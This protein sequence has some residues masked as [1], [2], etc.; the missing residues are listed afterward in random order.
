MISEAVMS[1]ALEWQQSDP[2]GCLG[3]Q[4]DHGEVHDNIKLVGERIRCSTRP[5]VVIRIKGRAIF[6]HTF[7]KRTGGIKAS[8][9]SQSLQPP[10][11]K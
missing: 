8:L 6:A 1:K 5:A 10:R 2:D 9:L 11:A 7:H 4:Y 3:V